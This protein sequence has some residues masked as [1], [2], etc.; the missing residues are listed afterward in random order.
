MATVTLYGHLARE[1]GPKFELDVHSPA[2]AIRA[3]IANFPAFK[4]H[5]E[6]SYYHILVDDLPQDLEDFGRVSGS[7]QHIKIVPAIAG[8]KSGVLQAIAGVALIAAAVF[9]P[10]LQGLAAYAVGGLGVAMASSGLASMLT[11]TPVVNDGSTAANRIEN[12][13]FSGAV[14]TEAQGRAIPI[15]IGEF[16]VG[17]LVVSSS[18]VVE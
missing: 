9:V 14:N 3:L 8:S 10:G 16:L 18:T 4:K 17:S 2:E 6:P 11:P 15:V 5:F 1:F 12:K 13:Y 7:S